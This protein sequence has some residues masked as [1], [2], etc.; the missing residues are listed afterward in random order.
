MKF[1]PQ[2]YCPHNHHKYG[3]LGQFNYIKYSSWT[4]DKYLNHVYSII[5]YRAHHAPPNIQRKWKLLDRK[6]N[7][8][9]RKIL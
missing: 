8:K 2:H 7:N 5:H 9:Y 3:P 6:F 4:I 1:R